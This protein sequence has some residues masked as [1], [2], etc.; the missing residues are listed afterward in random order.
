MKQGK[1]SCCQQEGP[2]TSHHI[3]PVRYHKGL[4]RKVL[5]CWEC[6]CEIEKEIPQNEEMETDFYYQVIWKF[7]ID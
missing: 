1:C 3:L 4:G 6:H 5:V 7:G 2:L